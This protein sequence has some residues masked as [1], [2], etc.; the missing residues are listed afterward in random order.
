MM[1]NRVLNWLKGQKLLIPFGLVALLPVFL[2]IASGIGSLKLDMIRNLFSQ[3]SMVL[4]FKTFFYAFGV[5]FV[6]VVIGSLTSL[7]LLEISERFSRKFMMILLFL[8]PVPSAVFAL[9]WMEVVMTFGGSWLKQT[10]WG[11]SGLVQ[12]VHMLPLSIFILYFG[13]KR[14]PAQPIEAGMFLARP[15]M[16]FWKIWLPA[17]RPVLTMTGLM[18]FILTI[19][20]YSIPASFSVNTYSMD[21]FAKYSISL[22]AA[23]AFVTSLPLLVLCMIS[24]IPASKILISNYL[25]EASDQ[26]LHLSMIE[27]AKYKYIYWLISILVL[28]IMMIPMSILLVKVNFG[29]WISVLDTSAGEILFTLGICLTAGI[30]GLPIMWMTALYLKAKPGMLWLVLTPLALSPSL[31]GAALIQIMN[32]SYLRWFYTSP[33]MLI[34]AVMIRFMPIGIIVILLAIN[35]LPDLYFAVGY[36]KSSSLFQIYRKIIIPIMLP[37]FL[38]AI[39]AVSLFGLGE[40]GTSVMIMPPG[41]STI[42]VKIYGYLH[43]GASEKIGGM[44][45]WVLLSILLILILLKSVINRGLK[46]NWLIKEGKDD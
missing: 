24:L 13:L 37:F 36:L 1:E 34:L 9:T 17:S 33:L 20:D 23:E 45:L 18:V 22:S 15:S 41:F 3:R 7:I 16:V 21:I 5:A 39:G 28:V 30:I 29:E 40:L 32:Q 8:I 12:T 4:M 44:S 26:K 10:G 25:Y 11:I 43:Y 35:Y 2:F 38:M 46:G 27:Y 6:C 14:L 31:I 19:N 42:T